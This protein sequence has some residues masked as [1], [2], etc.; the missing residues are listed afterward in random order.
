MRES[1]HKLD[2]V[3]SPYTEAVIYTSILYCYSTAPLRFSTEIKTY[4]E[5]QISTTVH[6]QFNLTYGT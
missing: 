1:K 5:S 3:L 6:G 4:H 2:Y